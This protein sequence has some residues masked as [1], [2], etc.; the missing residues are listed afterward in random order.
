MVVDLEWLIRISW[1]SFLDAILSTWW[2]FS[3]WPMENCVF[4]RTGDTIREMNNN[5]II[6]PRCLFM[7]LVS[8]FIFCHFRFFL[9]RSLSILSKMN[10]TLLLWNGKEK[11]NA[12]IHHNEW[13]LFLYFKV[14]MKTLLSNDYSI[15]NIPV[16]LFL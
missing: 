6:P 9:C 4:Y 3:S 12:V 5:K 13:F 11:K 1:V 14:S 15:C 16:T 10:W 2:H 7:S 8:L